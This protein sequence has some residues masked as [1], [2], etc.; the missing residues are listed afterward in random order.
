MKMVR[1]SIYLDFNFSQ[2]RD[3]VLNMFY[4]FIH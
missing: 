1:P 4:M 3:I 2:E